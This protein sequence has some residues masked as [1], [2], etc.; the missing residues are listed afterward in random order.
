MY[1]PQLEQ[2]LSPTQ[3]GDV[4]ASQ[5][6]LAQMQQQQMMQRAMQAF[7]QSLIQRLNPRIGTP[8]DTDQMAMLAMK[9][10]VKL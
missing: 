7:Q 9:L 6:A 10:G 5:K 4:A 8:Q 1:S 3:Q 2:A